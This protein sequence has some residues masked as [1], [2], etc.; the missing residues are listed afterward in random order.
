MEFRRKITK[1]QLLILLNNCTPI[2]LLNY[3][4][5]RKPGSLERREL[6]VP[7]LTQLQ[8]RI[9]VPESLMGVA[10]PLLHW[11]CRWSQIHPEC[12]LGVKLVLLC[13]VLG[14]L[15][16][17]FHFVLLILLLFIQILNETIPEGS[18]LDWDVYWSDFLGLLLL[19][20]D[21]YSWEVSEI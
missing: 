6:P 7:L 4:E 14:V 10:G 20:S 16:C 1:D 13:H 18:L 17:H 12:V 9:L 2:D 11:L 15:G 21:G 3:P 8:K 19:V 5:S